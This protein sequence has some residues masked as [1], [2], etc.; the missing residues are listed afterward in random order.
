MFEKPSNLI[1]PS[2]LGSFGRARI[3]LYLKSAENANEV[4]AIGYVQVQAYTICDDKK[5]LITDGLNA[6]AALGI[7]TQ[8]KVFLAH[9]PRDM[10]GVSA[11][12][13]SIK[14]E[15]AVDSFVNNN[16]KLKIWL[17]SWEGESNSL[18]MILE[19]LYK[20]KLLD[21]FV[22]QLQQHIK[23]HIKEPKKQEDSYINRFFL[24]FNKSLNMSQFLAMK[25]VK[26]KS[27]I[28]KIA[29]F[30]DSIKNEFKN[31]PDFILEKTE[32]EQFCST[33]KLIDLPKKAEDAKV[34]NQVVLKKIK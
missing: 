22:Q 29:R 9:V 1:I 16:I 33:N 32:F 14:R 18:D 19:L 20:L 26:N 6:C 23:E 8:D 5:E 4:N 12:Y 15:F 21:R 24:L 30:I 3:D 34:H 2:K 25:S 31:L 7:A 13:E 10:P 28:N 17:G 11:M 27:D